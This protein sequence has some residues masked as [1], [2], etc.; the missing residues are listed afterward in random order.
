M[1]GIGEHELLLMAQGASAEEK[2]TQEET[3]RSS[4]VPCTY[5]E[6]RMREIAIERPARHKVLEESCSPDEGLEDGASSCGVGSASSRPRPSRYW[7]SFN[8]LPSSAPSLNRF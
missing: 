5:G 1:L 4:E 3:R 8:N 6:C 2:R 7:I